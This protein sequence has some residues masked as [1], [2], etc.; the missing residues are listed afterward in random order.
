M[1]SLI[2]IY[3]GGFLTLVIA[4]YHTQLYKKLNWSE[5]FDKIDINNA[6]IFYTIN[7]ALTILFFLIGAISIFYARE[8]SESNGLA[9]GFCFSYSIFWIWRLIWQVTYQKKGKEQNSN[10]PEIAK[11]LI[12]FV[13]AFCYIFPFISNTF[14]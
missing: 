6:K 2:S 8:L 5:E 7:L 14:L 10:Q 13:I 3:I 9:F 12:P 1:S 11:I 4:F